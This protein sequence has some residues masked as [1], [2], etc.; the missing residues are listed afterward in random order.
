MLDIFQYCC[1]WK[2][3]Q[4]P[5]G[6][7]CWNFSILAVSFCC[8]R[9]IDCLTDRIKIPSYFSFISW[10]LKWVKLLISG[11]YPKSHGRKGEGRHAWRSRTCFRVIQRISS[12]TNLHKSAVMVKQIHFLYLLYFY[13]S[14]KLK[15]KYELSLK[16]Q[17][18]SSTHEHSRS[19]MHIWS[20]RA[21]RHL[22][23][24]AYW[25]KHRSGCF[26]RDVARKPCKLQ[27]SFAIF[28][29]FYSTSL[30]LIRSLL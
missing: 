25:F 16:S 27:I 8:T 29:T 18:C 4:S 12:A 20:P 15:H 11:K 17:G 13:F 30:S 7:V 22:R 21:S 1:L 26:K 24:L 14:I 28:R 3:K 23:W 2:K 6:L 9:S 10:R 19:I 5:T